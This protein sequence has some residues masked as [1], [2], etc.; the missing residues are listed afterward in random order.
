MV[1]D[2]PLMPFA[3]YTAVGNLPAAAAGSAPLLQARNPARPKPKAKA[4][5]QGKA[6]PKVLAKSRAKSPARVRE[7]S[8]SWQQLALS[9]HPQERLRRRNQLVLANLPLARAIVARAATK[10]QLPYDD[11]VQVASIGLIRAVEAFDPQRSVSFSTFAVPYIR[12]ALLHELRDRQPI[13]AIPRPLWELR[14]QASRLQE[15]RR[16]GGLPPLDRGE[17]AVQL[18]CTPQRLSE[19]EGL[20]EASQPRSLDAPLGPAGPGGSHGEASCLL[21]RLADPRSLAE[22]SPDPAPIDDPQ[23]AERAWLKQQLAS[24]DPGRR[25]LLDGRLRLGCTWVELGRQL[26]IHPRMAQRRCDAALAELQQAAARWQADRSAT[27]PS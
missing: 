15:Q 16:R 27:K 7:Q 11:L 8:P 9:S 10:P 18:G 20:R 6:Q 5:I 3:S 24:L 23:Q 12:G 21:D 19:I 25:Q 13:V 1:L 17:L 22:A 26:G 14:Q 4:K 2:L